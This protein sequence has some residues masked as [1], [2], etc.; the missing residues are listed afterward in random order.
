M[1]R[2]IRDQLR[3]TPKGS[4]PPVRTSQTKP[5]LNHDN[6]RCDVCRSITFECLVE[7][8]YRNKVISEDIKILAGALTIAPINVEACL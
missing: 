7:I 8:A 3:Q 2:N 6:G 5:G 4:P 1:Y